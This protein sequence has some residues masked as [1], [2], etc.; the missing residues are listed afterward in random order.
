MI[1][2]IREG[3]VASRI[4]KSLTLPKSSELDSTIKVSWKSGNPDVISD[5][6]K[7]TPPA[8]DT[9]V[10]MTVTCEQGSISKSRDIE[11]MVLSDST[12]EYALTID[13]ANRGVDISQELFGIFY[14]D[15][16]SAADGGL[17]TEIV[18]N[19]S[20]EEASLEE[21]QR[22]ELHRRADRWIK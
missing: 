9:K 22:F 20:F 8:K 12:T 5:D 21:Q 17:S 19:N 14:E 13:Q 2:E 10:K 3:R 1:P 4:C 18:K 6:G 15:I 16:N 7:I 11:F